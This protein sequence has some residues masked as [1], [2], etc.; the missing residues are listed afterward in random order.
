MR[1]LL[2]AAAA[3]AL[4]GA[5]PIPPNQQQLE[6]ALHQVALTV[7]LSNVNTTAARV[8][9]PAA[10][11]LPLLC[12]GVELDAEATAAVEAARAAAAA[13]VAS[14]TWPTPPPSPLPAAPKYAFYVSPTGSDGVPGTSPSAPFATLA[15]AQAAMR[16]V[17]VA[18]R[19]AGGAVVWLAGGTYHLNAT[20]VL[21][22]EDSYVAWAAAPGETP[23]LTGSVRVA[24][25]GGWAPMAP[26]SPVLVA[27]VALPDARREAWVAGGRAGAP[28]PAAVNQLFVDGARMVRAR[29]PNA[30]PAVTSGLCFSKPQRPGEG[31]DAWAHCIVGDLGL[32]PAPPSVYSVDPRAPLTP[33]RGASPTEGCDQCTVYGTFSMYSVFPP[34]AGHPVYT[35]PLPGTGWQNTSVWTAWPSLFARP[36]G[37]VVSS[38]CDARLGE[39]LPAVAAA[40]DAAGAVVAMFHGSLWGGWHFGG[41]NISAAPG[42]NL[43][44]GF[45][46][47]GFQEARGGRIN[48]GGNASGT[49]WYIEN[50][51]ALL[52]A[53][54]EWFY[55][56]DGA[57]LYVYPNASGPLGEVTV[58]LLDALVRVQGDPAAPGGP[59]YVRGVALVGLTLTQTRMTVLEQYEVPSGGDWSVHR[60]AAV[61]VQ[62]AEG[63]AVAGCTFTEV[64]GN[65][66][67]LSN[68]VANASI[69]ANEMV[70]LGDSGVVLVGSSV[71]DD[72]SAPTYPSGNLIG[73]NLIH[74]VGVYGKQTSCV[75]LAKSNATIRGNVC[76]NGPRAG[77][78]FN[79]GFVGGNIMGHNLVWNM[80]RETGDHGGLNSWD[81]LPYWTYSGVDDGFH[82]PQG[83][84][85][86]KATDVVTRNFLINGYNGVWSLDHDGEARGGG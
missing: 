63:V 6:C 59:A 29:F 7:A 69:V 58:P 64:G 27:P 14:G 86:L 8:A 33:N 28:P 15:R 47:G 68:H 9:V 38:A 11:N 76:F 75:F 4:A 74:E 39:V 79:D 66:V 80:V 53:P 21:T 37:I 10:L 46:Y 85:L 49:P 48:T 16:G 20:L 3:A 51:L 1:A 65:A 41:I 60:G 42:G 72:G 82:D 56:P 17:P 54:G 81:R 84:S 13:A 73:F 31:C 34:P 44:V 83:R 26:G 30:D 52:D 19:Q 12:D 45:A 77:I 57:R 35:S 25:P 78:N 23:V 2:A 5:S 61:E 70:R 67:L 55:D 62:D 24:P 32:Q 43:V 18:A 36:A 22:P 50:S 40:G 71:R